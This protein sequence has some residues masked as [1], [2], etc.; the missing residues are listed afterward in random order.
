MNTANSS[1]DKSDHSSEGGSSG[2]ELDVTK[3]QPTANK[4]EARPKILIAEDEPDARQ[5]F[6]TILQSQNKYEVSSAVDGIDALAKAAADKFNLI[7][8]DIVMPNKDG[9]EVLQ[10][11]KS[12]TA[13]YGTPIVVMLT[14]ISGDVAVEKAMELGAAGYK[15]KIETEPDELIQAVEDFLNGKIQD[16]TKEPVSRSLIGGVNP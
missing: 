9:V 16:V 4:A 10:E 13:K 6:T 14:N 1:V 7:L 5:I 11:L 2:M 12:D 3:L 8:L 15:L